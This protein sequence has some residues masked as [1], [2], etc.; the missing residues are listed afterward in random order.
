MNS[1]T[2][3]MCVVALILGMLLAHML[4][5]VCGCKTVEGTESAPGTEGACC[6]DDNDCRSGNCD[7]DKDSNKYCKKFK[8]LGSCT[9]PT[10]SQVQSWNARTMH[11]Q[12]KGACC[13]MDANCG[14]NLTC[15]PN[16]DCAEILENWSGAGI[17]SPSTKPP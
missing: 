11:K 1:Q 12:I 6:S 14:P 4:K 8:G 9:K 17:C 10:V 15:T 2:V 13:Y 16:N 5:D 3:V 7:S